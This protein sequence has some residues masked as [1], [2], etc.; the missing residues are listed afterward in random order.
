MRIRH[1]MLAFAGAALAG[2]AAQSQG[3]MCE[4]FGPCMTPAQIRQAV[5][6]ASAYAL[7]SERNPIRSDMPPGER[8]YL[9]RLRCSDGSAPAYDR[10]GSVGEGP[11]GGIMDV[12]VVRCVSG[13]PAE[14][15]VYMDMYHSG[16]EEDR[17]VPGFTIVPRG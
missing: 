6:K 13:T 15:Q 5:T 17:P 9:D 4:L 10:G 7:G 14:A 12:Y 1:L 2:S 11:F 3:P 16:Y 8:A